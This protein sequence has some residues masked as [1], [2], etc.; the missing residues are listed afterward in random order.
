MY[1]DNEDDYFERWRQHASI[2][3]RNV[4]AAAVLYSLAFVGGIAVCIFAFTKLRGHN[5]CAVSWLKASCILFTLYCVLE[6]ITSAIAAPL[7]H[8]EAQYY[9]RG[10]ANIDNDGLENLSWAQAYLS[11]IGEWLHAIAKAVICITIVAACAT[12]DRV[13]RGLRACS[14]VSYVVGALAFALATATFGLMLRRFYLVTHNVEY[15]QLNPLLVAYLYSYL[16]L[17][18]LLAAAAIFTTVVSMSVVSKSMH[19]PAHSKSAKLVVFSGVLM[20]L[21]T[22]FRLAWLVRY[23]FIAPAEFGTPAY[24]TVLEVILDAW[25]MLG[26]LALLFLSAQGWGDKSSKQYTGTVA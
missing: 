19:T 16:A 1:Y 17:A 25:P 15:Y 26:A 22:L 5:G 3:Y 4:I 7:E 10:Y 11:T 24:L 18:C 21:S 23:A 2:L 14:A 6:L 13:G 20:L 12:S 9:G 8:E